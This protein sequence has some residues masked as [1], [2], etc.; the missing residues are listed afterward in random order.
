M[1]CWDLTWLANVVGFDF[2]ESNECAIAIA[3]ALLYNM[4]G[5]AMCVDGR[6]RSIVARFEGLPRVGAL[7]QACM[8]DSCGKCEG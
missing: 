3:M 1:R 2:V 6:E 7:W 5:F 4:M 8:F